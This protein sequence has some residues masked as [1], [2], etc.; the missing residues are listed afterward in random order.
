MVSIFTTNKIKIPEKNV[1]KTFVL[2]S[3]YI[4]EIKLFPETICLFLMQD[5]M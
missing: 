5:G 2:H 1:D 4:K 3:T